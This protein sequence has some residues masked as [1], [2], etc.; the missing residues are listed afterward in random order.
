MK[1]LFREGVLFEKSEIWAEGLDKWCHLSAVSQFRW[2]IC[3]RGK[4][5]AANSVLEV[6]ETNEQVEDAIPMGL[7]NLTDLCT[8][9]LDTLVQMCSFFPSR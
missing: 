1:Q 5:M 9:I 2:T 8:L 3:C 7:Y 6:G 4:E